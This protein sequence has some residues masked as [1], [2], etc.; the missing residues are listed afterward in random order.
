VVFL[1]GWGLSHRAYRRSLQHIAAHGVRVIAPALPGSSGTAGLP[2]DDC[3]LE[4]YA[5]W[6]VSFLDAVEVDGPVLL[7]GHSF[8]GGVAIRTAHDHPDRVGGL[9][10]VNSIG[11]AVW[12][13]EGELARPMSDRPL[14]DWGL[15]FSRDLRSIGTRVTRVLPVMLAEAVP[16]LVF[17]PRAFLRSARLARDADLTDELETLNRRGLPVVVVW[18][19]RDGV[20]TEASFDALR[21]ALGDAETITVPGGHNWLLA[22]PDRFG[23]VITNVVE[24]AERARWMRKHRA[25]RHWRRLRERVRTAVRS[26]RAE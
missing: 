9:V 26:T 8:G 22:D 25:R 4:G 21:D 18:A 5:T 17:D 10:L 19:P 3:T 6:L 15:H 1:H 2:A 11:G 20:I 16:N 23:Q 12:S 24:V 13:G 14:W 7:V